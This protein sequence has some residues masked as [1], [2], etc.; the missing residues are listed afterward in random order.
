MRISISFFLC[1][2]CFMSTPSLAN[3]SAVLLKHDLAIQKGKSD[4]KKSFIHVVQKRETMS[5]ILKRYKISLSKFLKSNNKFVN[6]NL[7]LAIGENLIIKN[8]DMKTATSSEINHQIRVYIEESQVLLSKSLTGKYVNNKI[9][10][11]PYIVAEFD[12][13]ANNNPLKT[14]ENGIKAVLLLPLTKNNSQIDSDFE[15][16]YKGAVLAL[17]S[18]KR[19]GI[20]MTIDVYDTG[21]DM[22]KINSLISDGSLDCANIII[23]PIFN[24]QFNVVA[25]YVK[26]KGII[27]VSPLASVD[28]EGSFIYQV[29]PSQMT[30]YDKLKSKLKDK[31]V[32]FFS[33][34]GSNN[35]SFY[36]SMIM[37]VAVENLTAMEYNNE[38]KDDELVTYFSKKKKN[39]VVISSNKLSDIELLLSKVVS[40]KNSYGGYQIEVIGSPE[41]A[42][43]SD[44]KRN[45]FFKANTSYV[46]SSHIDRYNDKSLAFE[47]KYIDMFGERPTR[48]SDKAYDVTLM[49]I[50]MMNNFEEDFVDNFYDQLARILQVDYRFIQE[51][52]GGKNINQEWM[53]VHYKPNYTISTK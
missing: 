53:V 31:N 48:Y 49:F 37:E 13:T 27:L 21:K 52:E 44:G 50:R 11:R 19:S 8:K 5:M 3:V 32:I 35:E 6:T 17:D 41:F 12:E 43:I 38:M 47:T 25:D 42:K 29:A 20:S 30:R 7:S 45:D 26:S 40:I 4:N 9:V 51:N 2:F 23:G 10:E 14:W 18:L 36:T 24:D 15:S 16:F 1:F 33:H 22:F 39:V 34:N 46:T 28:A